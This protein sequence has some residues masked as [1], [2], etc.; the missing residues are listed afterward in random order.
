MSEVQYGSY[1]EPAPARSLGRDEIA[2]GISGI[3]IL[4]VL[5]KNGMETETDMARE[6]GIDSET[7]LPVL[8]AL[9]ASWLT[10]R[11]GVR[12]GSRQIRL[13]TRG[14]KIAEK[15]LGSGTIRPESNVQ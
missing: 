14:K 2:T 6:L 9:E 5:L 3:E 4:A 1:L 15:L 12:T 8:E 11:N 10:E 7:L 13:T